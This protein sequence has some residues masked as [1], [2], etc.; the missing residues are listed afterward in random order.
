MPTFA[1]AMKRLHLLAPLL[2]AGCFRPNAH[3][4]LRIRDD[5]PAGGDRF[6]LALYQSVGVAMKPGHQIELIKNGAVF[7]ELVGEIERAKTSIHI[8]AFIWKPGQPGDRLVDAILAKTLQG[9]ECRIMVDSLGSQGFELE[10]KP[11]LTAG[12]CDVR[13]FRPLADGPLHKAVNRNHRKIAIID[14]SVAI[15]GGYCIYSDWLGNGMSEHEWRDNNVRVRGPAVRDMQL[16]FAQ[17]WQ[18]VGGPLLPSNA[19]VNEDQ[20]KTAFGRKVDD[21][22][23]VEVAAL[24]TETTARAAFVS[25]TATSGLTAAE[26][27][28]QVVIAAAKKRIWITNAYFIPSDALVEVLVAKAKAGVD[29]KVVAAGRV[30]DWRTV[31]AAQRNTYLPLLRAGVR[32][33]EYQPSMM[34]AKTIVIDDSLVVVGSVNI[35]PLSMKKLEEG[36]LVAEDPSLNKAMAKAFEEDTTHSAEI[37]REGWEHRGLFD[38]LGQKMSNVVGEVL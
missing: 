32:I 9:V 5:I 6:S 26:R 19:F 8:V 7:D 38:Q 11:R 34:H 1:V 35:D 14:G 21:G 22:T 30:H 29:V 13:L 25:S 28:L 4:D 16:A 27:M 36:S 24:R 3:S 18:E 17:N 37:Q 33:W 10:V 2:L 12:G 31:R 20:G 23:A 15:T